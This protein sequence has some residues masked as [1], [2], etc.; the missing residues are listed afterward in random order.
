MHVLGVDCAIDVAQCVSEY[1]ITG[2][3]GEEFFVA[4]KA[5][6]DRLGP[7]GASQHQCHDDRPCGGRHAP[8]CRCLLAD[9]GECG[10]GRHPPCNQHRQWN[11]VG[12]ECHGIE[13]VGQQR[14]HGNVAQAFDQVHD[15]QD[16]KQGKPRD[17]DAP[18]E[19]GAQSERSDGGEHQQQAV[20]HQQ[21]FPALPPVF[22]KHRLVKQ[23]RSHHHQGDGKTHGDEC[24]GD[25]RQSAQTFVVFFVV[26]CQTVQ[27]MTQ[28]KKREV[29]GAGGM[30]ERDGKKRQAQPQ[31]V[32][33]VALFGVSK[34]DQYA[35]HQAELTGHARVARIKRLCEQPEAEAHC[36]HGMSTCTVSVQRSHD[37]EHQDKER[38]VAELKD[39]PTGVK[40]GQDRYPSS[41]GREGR[42][43]RPEPF[44]RS[45]QGEIPLK[46]KLLCEHGEANP[47]HAEGEFL[48]QGREEGGGGNRHAKGVEDR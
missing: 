29:N 11:V 10:V 35:D 9:R 33:A 38:V 2:R 42:G 14:Q 21:G 40:T 6:C 47:V 19:G 48:K 46:D 8:R 36:E 12:V 18:L 41:R 31:R 27:D 39:S 43:V 13:R 28:Q 17:G 20:V 3:N 5:E 23:T 37:A 22:R 1:Q 25:V 34:Q 32:V 30:N 26:Q 45:R 4:G 24:R 44:V 16:P 7:E 15:A